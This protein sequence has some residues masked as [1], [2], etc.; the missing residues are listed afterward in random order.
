MNLPPWFRNTLGASA[1]VS[2]RE[3]FFVMGCQKSGT[4]WVQQLLSGHPR[5]CCR[6]EGHF[7]DVVGPLME[8]LVSV[9]NERPRTNLVL[10]QCA[11]FS[12]ARVLCDQIL[13]G[14]LTGCEDPKIVRAIG[15]KTPETALRVLGS[16]FRNFILSLSR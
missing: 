1:A 5:V 6:G 7:G 12:L 3:V 16:V 2:E 15:D 11:V 4:T 8:Q 14:Y 10:D 13:A 9:Y